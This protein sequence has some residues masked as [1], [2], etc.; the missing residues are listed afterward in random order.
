AAGTV[1][2]Q[3]NAAPANRAD[4]A[5]HLLDGR[6][7]KHPKLTHGLLSIK[8]TQAGDRIALRLQAGNPD[9]LQVDVGDDGSSDFSFKRDKI[10]KIA[11]DAQAGDDIVRIDESNGVFTDSIP[12]TLDA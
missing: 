11:V 6:K 7:F 5:S 12:T 4:K 9:M 10:T 3:G 8:G 1:T 2:G